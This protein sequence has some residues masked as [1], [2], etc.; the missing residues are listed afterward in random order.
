MRK[1]KLLAIAIV[2]ALAGFVYAFGQAQGA[3]DSCSIDKGACCAKCCESKDTCC[4]AHKADNRQ[5]A[6]AHNMAKDCASCDCSK[7]EGSCCKTDKDGKMQMKDGSCAQ[8]KDGKSCCG[9]DCCKDACCT[10]EKGKTS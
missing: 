3:K 6:A 9:S 1:I 4:K 7:G 8:D 2:F 5:P 10:K